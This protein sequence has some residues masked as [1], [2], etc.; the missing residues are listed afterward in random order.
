MRDDL[1][2]RAFTFDGVLKDTART[3]YDEIQTIV[4]SSDRGLELNWNGLVN[5]AEDTHD[6]WDFLLVGFTRRAQTPSRA[7]FEELARDNE[8]AIEV[9]DSSCARFSFKSDVLTQR[10]LRTFPSAQPLTL[11]ICRSGLAGRIDIIPI[12]PG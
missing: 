11:S 12:L 3:T 2:F 7:T 9:F 6:V 1:T 5:L 10:A 8:V 4:D